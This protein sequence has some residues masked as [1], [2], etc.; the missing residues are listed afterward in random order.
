MTKDELLGQIETDY[1]QFVRYLSYFRM[2]EH[3]HFVPIELPSSW[4]TLPT[5]IDGQRCIL[6]SRYD[7]EWNRI[8]RYNPEQCCILQVQQHDLR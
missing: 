5:T 6:A 2:S 3:G 8:T 4:S 1:R 7:P